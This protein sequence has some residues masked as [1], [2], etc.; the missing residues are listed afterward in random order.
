MD[1]DDATKEREAGRREELPADA[2]IEIAALARRAK[3]AN[4]PLMRAFNRLGGGVESQM[5]ALPAKVRETL[6]HGTEGLLRGA[7]SAA[8]AVGSLKAV[9]ETGDWA[10]R[11]AVATGGALGGR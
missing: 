3:R 4:G 1:H 5:S 7:Y 9:P 2:L 11:M 6:E 8:G 10:H